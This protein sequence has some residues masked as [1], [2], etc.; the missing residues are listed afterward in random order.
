[1]ER[2][3]GS[4]EA[5]LTMVTSRAMQLLNYLRYLNL[6]KSFVYFSVG[7]VPQHDQL[8]LA[9]PQMIGL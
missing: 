3:L 6:Q 9:S 8:R 5:S 1:M 4:S 7:L 2:I